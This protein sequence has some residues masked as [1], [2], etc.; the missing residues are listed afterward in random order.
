[1]NLAVI[2]VIAL[3]NGGCWLS[4]QPA[5]ISLHPAV[6]G[7]LDDA[8]VL[9]ELKFGR[10]TLAEGKTAIKRGDD[11]RG[12]ILCCL[13]PAC[14]VTL[15]W[16]YQVISRDGKRELETGSVPVQLFPPDLMEG[17]AQ[18]VGRKKLVVWVRGEEWV[19]CWIA[20]KSLACIGPLQAAWI[21][22]KPMF[23]WWI[24]IRS[25]IRHLAISPDESSGGWRVSNAF[26]ADTAP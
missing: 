15:H 26:Q 19:N 14:A 11:S 6:A 18:R 17:V 2:L 13:I 22:W 8:E 9:W 21:L 23:C 10:V 7:V 24:A 12:F 1:M 5:T 20:P 4:G 25:A 16:H 3:S